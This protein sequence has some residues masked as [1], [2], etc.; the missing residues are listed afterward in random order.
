M[1]TFGYR[2]WVARRTTNL[3]NLHWIFGEKMVFLYLKN[4]VL[5]QSL[6]VLILIKNT[7]IKERLAQYA[8]VKLNWVQMDESKK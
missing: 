5:L 4:A 6:K 8:K 2:L 7:G 3:S 1:Q